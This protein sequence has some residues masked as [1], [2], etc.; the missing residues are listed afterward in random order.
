VIEIAN[1]A[2]WFGIG[3]RIHPSVAK[4]DIIH[5]VTEWNVYIL[6]KFYHAITIII[7]GA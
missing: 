2:W 3:T 4:V 1:C 6:G 7:G 5:Q